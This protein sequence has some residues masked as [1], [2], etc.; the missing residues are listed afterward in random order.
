MQATNLTT[1]IVRYGGSYFKYIIYKLLGNKTITF[2]DVLDQSDNG[3][4][5]V[6]FIL[7]ICFIIYIIQ[8]YNI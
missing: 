2:K 7:L 5:K 4:Y 8:M 1:K 3:F 6:L